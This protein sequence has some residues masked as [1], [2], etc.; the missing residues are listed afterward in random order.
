MLDEN[1]VYDTQRV[2]E[3]STVTE[4]A[5]PT[6]TQLCKTFGGWYAEGSETT[7]DFATPVNADLTW[8]PSGRRHSYETGRSGR[9]CS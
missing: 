4:P 7:Y 5:D 9:G 3:G 6:T 2:R 1:T 8:S